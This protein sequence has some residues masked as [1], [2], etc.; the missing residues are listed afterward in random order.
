[1]KKIFVTE[2]QFKKIV[3]ESLKKSASNAIHQAITPNGRIAEPD[4]FGRNF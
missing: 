3:E 4:E 1:M 2:N